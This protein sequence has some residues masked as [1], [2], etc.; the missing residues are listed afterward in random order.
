MSLEPGFATVSSRRLGTTSLARF[1]VTVETPQMDPGPVLYTW[2]ADAAI[3]YQVVGEGE[4]DLFYLGTWGSTLETSWSF[5]PHARFLRGLAAFSRLVLH[6]GR[7]HGSSDGPSDGRVVTVDQRADDLLAVADSVNTRSPVLFGAQESAMVAMSVAATRPWAF[8]S[9]VLYEPAPVWS[10][11]DELPWETRKEENQALIESLRRTSSY[12][13]WTRSQVRSALPSLAADPRTVAWLAAA[14]RAYAPPAATIAEVEYLDT[15]DLTDLLPKIAL[16]T[17]VLHRPEAQGWSS[18]TCAIRRGAHPRREGGRTAGPRPVPMGR[19]CRRR[20]RRGRGVRHRIT[21]RRGPREYRPLD[22]DGHVQRHRR[23]DH[24]GCDDRRCSMARPRREAPRD[25]S[26]CRSSVTGAVERDTAGDGFFATFDAP[27][28]ALR[29]GI[30]IVQAVQELGLDVRIGI[31]TGEVEAI[32][33]KPGGI[34]VSVGARI[35]ALAEGGEMLVSSTVKDLVA[36]SGLEFADAGGHEL[37]GIPG[38]WQLYR[39][40]IAR[41]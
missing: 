33:G 3:A 40:V 21:R 37:R 28:R 15:L 24:D 7:G 5:P 27:E 39:A 11:N 13:E 25:G 16:P 20:R 18:Q 17:L 32:D 1:R 30:D 35:A 14:Y 10:R 36:G 8:S 34:A 23:L 29:C 38:T 19:R 6:D 41:L 9:L 4:Q 2:S 26:R 12:D 22:R 31:H